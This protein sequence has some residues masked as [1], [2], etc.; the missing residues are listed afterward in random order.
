M[1]TRQGSRPAAAAALWG[2]L[3]VPLVIETATGPWNWPDVAE[4]TGGGALLAALVALRRRAPLGVLGAAVATAQVVELLA[5]ATS[6]S[7]RLWP[8]VATTVFAYLAGRRA[9]RGRPALLTAVTAAGLLV[10]PLIGLVSAG[11]FG[12]L[13]AAYDWF[14]LV[15]VLL[16]TAT[17]AWLLGR[18]LHQRAALVAAGWE[19]AALLERQQ[20]LEAE[21]AR[22]AERARIAQDMHDSL[23][24]EWTLIALRAAALEVSPHLDDESRATARD[25][26]AG[27]ATA[28]EHLHDVIT[29]LRAGAGERTDITALVERAAAAGMPVELVA[30]AEPPGLPLP[31]RQAAHR[32]VQE[33]L[34]NAAKH[35][36]G[37]PVTVRVEHVDDTTSVTITN[38]Q[39][40]T[41][42]TAPGHRTGGIGLPALDE[43][44]RA[45]GGTLQA[46]PDRAGFAVT[47]VIPHEGTPTEPPT[48]PDVARPRWSAP[49]GRF[50][51][52]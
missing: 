22:M 18:Y 49:A 46:G 28:T 45:V 17:P 6:G 20:L 16:L 44:V 11:R 4:L 51:G 23:G 40:R 27:V 47:A 52:A 25:L 8:L 43:R 14:S 26:R 34:T 13:L 21:R 48:A 33:G 39:A 10:T 38:G 35:A 3:V 30:D 5:P 31:V 7:A 36:R 32:V 2:L 41:T 15:L 12:L 1:R 29:V 50:A 37:A 42:S 19:R 24:H 9:S